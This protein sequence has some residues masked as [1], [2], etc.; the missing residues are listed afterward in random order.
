MPEMSPN[1]GRRICATN[2][3]LADIL[4]RMDLDLS[5]FY[6]FYLMD[7]KCLQSNACLAQEVFQNRKEESLILIRAGLLRKVEGCQMLVVD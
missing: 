5:F 4:G 6:V 7:P 3:N 1:G 2:P